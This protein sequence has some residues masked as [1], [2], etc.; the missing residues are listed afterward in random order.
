MNNYCKWF[1]LYSNKIDFTLHYFS[2]QGRLQ[3]SEE[4]LSG[5]QESRLA[6]KQ[7]AE[8]QYLAQEEEYKKKIQKFEEQIKSLVNI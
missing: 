8:K 6:E 4:S 2:S 5:E 7:E 3:R 1:P